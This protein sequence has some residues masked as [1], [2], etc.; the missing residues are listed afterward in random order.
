M[1]APIGYA[2]LQIIPSL[3]GVSKAMDKSLD[4]TML[5]AGKRGGKQLAKG[6]GDGMKD[7]E[8]E[9]EA[10]TKAYD[11][12]KD[13]ASDA[14]G[15]VRSDE[16]ALQRLRD[17]GA[18]DDRIVKAEERLAT[19]RRNSTRASREA[20][21]SHRSLRAAQQALGDSSDNLGRRFGGLSDFAG[22]AGKA[23]TGAAVV[24]AGAA[25]VGIGAL[26]AG[27][28][29]AGKAVYDLGAEFDDV[30][31]NIRVKTGATG[32]ALE[33]LQSATERLATKVP[34]SIG[35]IGDV[36]AETSRAL[37]LTGPDLDNTAKAIANLGRL[38]G[39]DV[40]VRSL[41]KAFRGFGVD[42]KD[43][44]PALDSLL[45]AS[46]STGVGVNELLATIV[47]GG[48]GLRQFGF[49]FGESAALATQFEEA[50]LD[51]SKALAGLTKGLA[52][53][54]KDGKTGEDALKGAVGEI[55]NL[56]AA[57]NDAGALDLTNKLFGAK[58]GVQFFE[59]IK[60]GA[61]D[62]DTLS[63]SLSNT[64]DTIAQAAADT[65]DWAERWEIFKNSIKVGLQP[66]A[67][68]VFD[69]VN[70]KLTELA[71]WVD[72]HKPE[73]I[74]FFGDLAAAVT[75]KT[76]EALRGLSTFISDGL[77]PILRSIEDFGKNNV[78]ANLIPG[79]EELGG[80]AGMLADGLGQLPDKL[81]S[82]A[83]N[84]DSLTPK[85]KTLADRTADAQRFTGAL[86]EATA[87]LP[88]GKTIELS[89]NAPETI[90]GLKAL[91]IEVTTLPNG[92]IG[93]T[94]NTDEG[95]RII[96]A[97]R[98]QETKAPIT[99]TVKP[100]L[101]LE[102]VDVSIGN[103]FKNLRPV[104]NPQLAPGWGG[105][106]GSFGPPSNPGTQ[107]TPHRA[108]G[109]IFDVWKSVASF[110][111]GKLPQQAMIQQP[112]GGAGL[113]QWAEP[114]TEGEAFIPLASSKR[115]RSRAIWAET[116]RR[117]G[118]HKFD[119]GGLMGPP[120]VPGESASA[121]AVRRAKWW[122]EHPD[123]AAKI[124]QQ[125]EGRSDGAGVGLSPLDNLWDWVSSQFADGGFLGIPPDV[126]AAQQLVGTKY[127]QG[128]RT[129]CSGMAA[130]VIARALG[131]PESGLMTT[132]NAAQWLA[133]A[134]FQQGMGGPGQISVGWYD[135]G[136]NPNDGHMA[137]TLSDGTH[138]E[139]GGKNSVFTLGANAS[140][141]DS[142][143]FDQH[144]FL[145]TLFGEGQSGGFSGFGGG[146]GGYSG[147][148]SSSGG[149]GT[150][151]VGPN[152]EAGT[153]SAPDAK[154]VR[155]ADEKVA[156]ADQRV[157]QAELKIKELDADAK[158][159]QRQA[160]QADLDKAKREAADARADR[161][162]VMKGKFT[163]G[164]GSDGGSGSG[165]KMSLSSTFSGFG[166]ALGE[167]AGG[168]IGS[169]LD[170]FGIGD[171]PPFLQAASKLI[172]G[173]SVGG[174]GGGSAAPLSASSL[175]GG[176]AIPPDITGN[177]HGTRAGQAPGPV[178]NTTIQARDAEGALE[179]WQR[180]QN[181]RV[182]AKTSV[183]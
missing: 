82:F 159:S 99:P 119:G 21:D 142:P 161:D 183:Y 132:K 135:H 49:D 6:V 180:L 168:Q 85:I 80:A 108:T 109:G 13:K 121:A 53:L 64:G 147:G 81:N 20:E 149:G 177:V 63:D 104:I 181:Q 34:L 7:L 76:A 93:V 42:A 26:A 175:L 12:L 48:A 18:S 122:E 5:A 94:A 31:D 136:P 46:Q 116:G 61:L 79:A 138:A 151:G 88:D 8:R 1:T 131:L 153:Y 72:Q 137:M 75:E 22:T 41:G 167:F 115:S 120:E 54:A 38:M 165:S 157:K 30:F 152:G 24:A 162:E 27:V 19:S 67:T 91:G 129:D 90:E 100:I 73:V 89:S 169:A 98:D 110:A 56:M 71:D 166:S 44:V 40:D 36:V 163:A 68:G 60:N 148:G 134:G 101:A 57:G 114:S 143:Q 170:V 124:K 117:L 111:N 172:G 179:G 133:A 127:D 97:F 150:P 83:G 87:S 178:Y 144:M 130:R 3:D 158:E 160:S 37:H 96:Q 14:L 171:S 103:Y 106:G 112:V 47:K 9:V 140:G 77:V 125:N 141:A 139:A 58:G 35:Q 10:A 11:K 17:T 155:E 62:L 102:G 69:A 156:D 113:V 173:I 59:A 84:V 39:E 164:G 32:P 25:V 146:S 118:V 145:P 28:V 52:G 33:Q 15:K 4:G 126:A 65:D 29:V 55:K 95:R 174:S 176:A 105:G 128:S 2:T 154:D 107:A 23:I 66:I 45:Q 92:N 86:G 51:S 43:Q 16:A 70:G 123:I 74:G 50:G 78:L 182:A